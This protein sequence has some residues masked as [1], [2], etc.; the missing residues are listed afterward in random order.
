MAQSPIIAPPRI[1]RWLTG[2]FTMDEQSEAIAGDLLE[3]FT[4]ISRSSGPAHARRWYWRQSVKTA[5]HL[6]LAAFRTAPWS[7]SACA[8]AGYFLLFYAS[9]LPDRVAT[10]YIASRPVIPY[11]DPAGPVWLLIRLCGIVIMPTIVGCLIAFVSK[12]RE[13]IAILPAA[14]LCTAQFIAFLVDFEIRTSRFMGTPF[15]FPPARVVV[16][17]FNF[18]VF[19]IFG[20][21]IIRRYRARS[22]HRRAE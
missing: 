17:V 21:A 6:A 11:V 19:P 14:L 20:A 12:R 16:V 3:E 22:S 8:V 4:E 1:A 15:A 9:S 13:I 5:W 18:L 7:V 10:A 2:L